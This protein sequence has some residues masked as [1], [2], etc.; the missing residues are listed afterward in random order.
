MKSNIK[1][2]SQSEWWLYSGIVVTGVTTFISITSATAGS[3]AQVLATA[4]S[5]LL[6]I[7][8]FTSGRWRTHDEQFYIF[9][10]I[11]SVGI[12]LIWYTWTYIVKKK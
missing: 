6:G 8:F 1:N 9:L 4:F 2:K 10:T 12:F 5:A 3:T 11:I 7:Y